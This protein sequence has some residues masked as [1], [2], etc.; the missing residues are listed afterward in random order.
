MRT[1]NNLGATLNRIS[2]TG[3]ETA[4]RSQALAYLTRSSEY[5]D[6]LSRDQESFVRSESKNLSVLN[7]RS[8]LYPDA[9]FNVEIYR[10]ISR[11]MNELEF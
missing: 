8:I 6:R 4:K 5:F 3:G 11:D 10:S 7:T 1:Y 9:G 2:E